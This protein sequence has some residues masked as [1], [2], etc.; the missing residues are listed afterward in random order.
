MRKGFM[1]IEICLILLGLALLISVTVRMLQEASD[2]FSY[3]FMQVS[4]TCEV[5][6]AIVKRIP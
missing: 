1:M 4:K 6:C 3:D 5:E 2:N